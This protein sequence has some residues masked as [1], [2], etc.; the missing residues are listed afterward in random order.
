MQDLVVNRG[1]A[2]WILDRRLIYVL[3]T[4]VFG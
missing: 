2:V 4:C 1:V 3:Y